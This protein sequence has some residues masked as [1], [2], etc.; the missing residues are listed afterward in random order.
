MDDEPGA[1]CILPLLVVC[2]IGLVLTL[3]CIVRWAWGAVY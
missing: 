2:V 3:V 1:G